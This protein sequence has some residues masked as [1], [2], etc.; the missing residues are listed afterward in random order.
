VR[1]TGAVKFF[2]ELVR[3]AKGGSCPRIPSSLPTGYWI[4]VLR[5]RAS[6]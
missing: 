6:V 2:E 1:R 3:R 5:R 4:R